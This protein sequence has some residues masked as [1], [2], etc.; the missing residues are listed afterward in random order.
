MELVSPVHGKII[1]DE[2]EIVTFKK[3]IPGF[4]DLKKYVIKKVSNE[5]PFSIV[6][7][8]EN[9]D[10]AFIVISPFDVESTYEI[11]LSDEIIKKVE[12]VSPEDIMLY[13]IVTLN[14]K[15]ENITANLKAPLVINIKKKIG[16]QFIGDKEIYQIKH[17]IIFK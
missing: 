16:E 5:S 12:V 15:V 8:I 11:E 14:S 10:I 3:G 7:S 13:S 4:E 6:Q 1:Y 2:D 17:P 9:K